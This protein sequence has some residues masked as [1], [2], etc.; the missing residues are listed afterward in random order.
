MI[1]NGYLEENF[2]VEYE[3]VVKHKWLY[4]AVESPSDSHHQTFAHPDYPNLMAFTPC[5]MHIF[6]ACPWIFWEFS[7][8]LF[9]H[10]LMEPF[11]LRVSATARMTPGCKRLGTMMGAAPFG[12]L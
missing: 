9:L 3:S 11:R 2:F 12:R 4:C 6:Y 8:H 1:L 10:L 7:Y 5:E